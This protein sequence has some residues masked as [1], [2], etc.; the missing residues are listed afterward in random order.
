M[1]IHEFFMCARAYV[2]DYYFKLGFLN[3]NTI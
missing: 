3:G 1:F 2:C